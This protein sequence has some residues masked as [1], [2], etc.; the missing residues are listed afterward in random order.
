[1]KHYLYSLLLLL[2]LVAMAG[3][4]LY[5]Q[6]DTVEHK[7]LSLTGD[8]RFR[9]EQDWNSQNQDGIRRDDRGR[10]RYRFRF[11][12][13]Y[14]IDRHSTF[15]GRLRSGNINDQQGP[16]VTLGGNNGEFELVSIGLEKLFYQFKHKNFKGWIGKNSIPLTKLNELFWNDNVFPEGIGLTYHM[17][18]DNQKW[19]DKI[20]V[21]AGHFII[22]SNGK[23]FA[24]DG[25][26]QM[27]QFTASLFQERLKLFPAYY[28]FNKIGNYPDGKATFDLDYSI[29]HL[30]SQIA[31]DPKRKL[32]LGIE[33]YGNIQDYARHDSIPDR[34]KDE[35]LGIVLSAQYGSMANKG[36]WLWYIA[37]ARMQQ[38]SIVDYFAQNDWSRWDYS[39]IGASGARITNFQGVEIKIGYAIKKHFNLNLR[40]YFVE[41][42]VKI[43]NFKE[44]GSRMRL[45][46]NIGF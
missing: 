46:L 31:L 35:T 23:S 34:F 41:Q 36:D 2:L 19:L 1:M 17:P 45:D 6:K 9:I 25:Y 38:F 18:F 24:E 20:T 26:L 21:N 32:K 30:G 44:N 13:Q 15:G 5:A 22:N 8:F 4:D 39:S 10:L 14:A 3:G 7:S 29:A 16:H 28:Y 37:Y 42:L 40:T 43:G 27:L 12:M 11:G 33:L